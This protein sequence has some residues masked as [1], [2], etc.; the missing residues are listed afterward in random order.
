VGE[1]EGVEARSPGPPE[2]RIDLPVDAHLPD[3]YVPAQQLRLEAYRRLA[4][5]TTHPEVD[6][7]AAEWE[8]RYGPLPQ[9]ATALMDIAR[10]R[11]EALRVGLTELVKLRREVRLAPVD[12]TPSQEVR[13]QRLARRAV[14]KAHQGALFL[15]APPEGKLVAGLIGFL[16]EMW[17]EEP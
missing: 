3:D 5:A 2:V 14:L 6:D 16:R 13:L 1:L 12:L 15:P 4:L 8:D 11:V 9:A 7:V 10:L 17:P